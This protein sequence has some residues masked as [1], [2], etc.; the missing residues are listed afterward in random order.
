MASGEANGVEVSHPLPY[1][2]LKIVGFGGLLGGGAQTGQ[3]PFRRH[4]GLHDL[5]TVGRGSRLYTYAQP[6]EAHGRCSAR[7]RRRR[8]ELY[9]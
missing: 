5:R 7:A 9:R 2:V 4:G 3:R 1:A 6:V 8:S